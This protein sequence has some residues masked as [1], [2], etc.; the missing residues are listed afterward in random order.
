MWSLCSGVLSLPRVCTLQLQPWGCHS[1]CV[2]PR[3]WEV[4]LQGDSFSCLCGS[5]TSSLNIY[6]HVVLC[7]SELHCCHICRKM[8][9]ASSVTSARTAPSTLTPPTLTAAPA[10]SV[11][12]QLTVVGAPANAEGRYVFCSCL[13]MSVNTVEIFLA[14]TVCVTWLS[15]D[16]MWSTVINSH[17]ICS[18][19]FWVCINM[20]IYMQRWNKHALC[21]STTFFHVISL[22]TWTAGAWKASTRKKLRPFWTQPVTRWWRTSRSFHPQS[23][24]ST[25]WHHPLIWET[26]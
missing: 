2:P 17:P 10:A 24:L 18:K 3:Q 1:R 11:L 12:G 14:F 20:C 13:C 26:R 5:K 21:F 8:L 6:V 25:G 16:I 4:S 23:R 19:K 7:C 15:A 9:L 22:L